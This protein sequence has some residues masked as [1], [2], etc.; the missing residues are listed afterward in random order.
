MKRIFI[1]LVP[2]ERRWRAYGLLDEDLRLLQLFLLLNPAAGDVIQGTNGI[3]KVRWAEGGKGK[4][5]GLR[6][7]FID[8]PAYERTYLITLIR[9]ADV[10]DLTISERQILATMVLELRRVLRHIKF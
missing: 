6:V 5:G 4:R 3:R 9:K 10:D 2:F 7:F 8:F 1:H